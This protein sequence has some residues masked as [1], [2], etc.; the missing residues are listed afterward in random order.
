MLLHWLYATA[1]GTGTTFV[2]TVFCAAHLVVWKVI[3]NISSSHFL[4]THQ[5]A[6]SEI[7]KSPHIYLY[8]KLQVYTGCLFVFSFHCNIYLCVQT[9]SIPSMGEALVCCSR[10]TL[11]FVCLFVCYSAL[12]LTAEDTTWHFYRRPKCH[13]IWTAESDIS[14]FCINVLD[15]HVFLLCFSQNVAA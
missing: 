5:T 11:L 8:G 3:L 9:F 6:H 2:R 7:Q 13:S 4:W 10:V 1:A 14:M 12:N 15:A